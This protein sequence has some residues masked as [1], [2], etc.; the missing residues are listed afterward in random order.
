[1]AHLLK[2]NSK[3]WLQYEIQDLWNIQIH[4]R[5]E[6][7]YLLTKLLSE[8]VVDADLLAP[9]TQPEEILVVMEDLTNFKSHK[10]LISTQ[11]QV[12]PLWNDLKTTFMNEYRQQRKASNQLMKIGSQVKEQNFH[13][14]KTSFSRKLRKAQYRLLWLN[15]AIELDTFRASSRNNTL[16]AHGQLKDFFEI[17]FNT[18][19]LL[20]IS[21]EFTSQRCMWCGKYGL[22]KGEVFT[23]NKNKPCP[24]YNIPVHADINASGTI[25]TDY[26]NDYRSK[27]EQKLHQL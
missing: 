6:F 18:R 13:L 27:H 15:I 7:S 8:E 21:P 25:T 3:R 14:K 16:W 23:C 2:N 11:Y 20:E 24:Y 5:L 22:R 12:N 10:A 17:K 26:L 4:D 19:N 1:M 9:N